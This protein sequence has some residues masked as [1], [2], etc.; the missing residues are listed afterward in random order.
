MLR[1]SVRNTGIIN[2][3]FFTVYFEKFVSKIE[4]QIGKNLSVNFILLLIVDIW[5]F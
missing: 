3:A 4:F 1:L 5:S 2:N